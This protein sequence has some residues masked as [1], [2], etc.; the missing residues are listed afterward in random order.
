MF[1]IEFQEGQTREFKQWLWLLSEGTIVAEDL[2]LH[3]DEWTGYVSMHVL[4]PHTHLWHEAGSS[5]SG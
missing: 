3:K 5:F 2:L 1:L 4:F